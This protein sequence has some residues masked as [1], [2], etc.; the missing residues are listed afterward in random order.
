M[1]TQSPSPAPVTAVEEPLV[2]PTYPLGTPEK[3][4]LFFEKRVY[5]GSSGKVYPVPFID[6]V[7]DDPIPVTYR[8]VRME[9]EFVRLILLPEIGGRIFIAQDKTNNDYDFFYRQEVIK[10][11]LVGLAGPW[12]SGGVEFNWPQHHRPGTFLPADF[13][14]EEGADG[15]RT[16]W[17]SE[18]DPI[19]R[20]KG[21]HGIR[22]VPGSSRVELL[23]RLYNRTPVTHSFLWW[24]NVAARVHEQYQSFFPEDV[25]FVADHAVR[26]MSSFPVAENFYYGVDYAA[27]PG[28]ND[29]TWYKNIPVPTSYMICGTDFDF[30]GGYDHAAGGGFVHVAD[31]RVAPGKKQWTWGNHAFGHAWDRE[32]T[33]PTA[34]GEYPPYIEL[35]AGVFTDNQPDFTYLRPGEVK[36]FRQVWWPYRGLGPVQQ[37]D[38]RFAI[39]LQAGGEGFVEAGVA[40]SQ[41]APGVKVRL[42]DAGR[43]LREDCV[44]L[45]PGRVWQM[46]EIHADVGDPGDLRL[47]VRGPDGDLLLAHQ[48]TRSDGRHRR[49]L[50]T[51]PRIPEAISSVEELYFT[52]EHLELYRHPTR[53][54]EA[55]WEEAIRRDGHDQRSHVAL[56]R[57][58]LGRGEPGM[59]AEHFSKAIGRLTE[60][61]PNPESGEAHYY[62]GLA[63][64][65][66]GRENEA[67]ECFA[68]ASWDA[69]W[70]AAAQ[71]ELAALELRE[72]NP[73][74]A[75]ESARAAQDGNRRGN[76][77]RVLEAIA[78]RLLGC[79]AAASAVLQALLAEDPLD[80]WAH[81]ELGL[82][83]GGAEAFFTATRNDAQTILDVVFDYTRCGQFHTAGE[84]LA[85][86]HDRATRPV[87]VPNPMERNIMTRYVA[88][89]IASRRGDDARAAA[90]LCEADGECGDYFFPSRPEEREVLEWVLSVRQDARAACALGC[91]FFDRKRHGDAIRL[92]Q[93]ATAWNERDALAWR[94]LGIALWNIPADRNGA[95]AAYERAIALEPENARLVAEFAQLRA[96][97]GEDPRERLAFLE[98]RMELVLQRDDACVELAALLNET[99]SPGRALELLCS[100]RFH[101]W[102]GGEGKVLRQYTRAR[103]LLGEQALES[104]DAEGAL[105]HFELALQT[106]ANLGEAYHLLQA[107]ADVNYRRGCALRALGRETEAR[108]AFR[109]AAEEAGDFQHMAVTAHS[110]L[111]VDRALSLHALGDTPRAVLLLD[112]VC[113]FARSKRATPARID[114]FATSLPNL[115]VFE[116]DLEAV[117]NAEAEHLMRLATL[118]RKKITAS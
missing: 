54:P 51:E 84:L 85:G 59:A 20:L 117:K 63:V 37:A 9:N 46:R 70:T 102:E 4:P 76:R 95:R 43:V 14:I 22:L 87:A 18:H 100:R 104:G 34:E 3:L 96:K 32:L 93:N 116:D 30:F 83:D 115:L 38:E 92:W 53:S 67:R 75:L 47:E 25:D 44:D 35:M 8:S 77:A 108:A 13:Y 74:K 114:Y 106:P 107:R 113:D 111:S 11:A 1:T 39:R 27:R 99:G 65:A 21:M 52:G 61:H 62:L 73:D 86:H 15:S 19:H 23:G 24:A 55:Y 28:A 10:P 72:G 110:E 2:I 33:D 41:A 105:E 16:V 45:A 29:L 5:Q 31:R 64:S 97:L 98:E 90:L 68:K 69:A 56:G 36:T 109:E 103:L 12:I 101:P 50:A 82:H 40:A 80:F 6:K 91:F 71:S 17:M 89:W 26:A 66:L 42:L 49:A 81:H 7:T 48:P 118:T 58:A 112:E 88:A 94:N 57:R 79:G 78:L 60:R